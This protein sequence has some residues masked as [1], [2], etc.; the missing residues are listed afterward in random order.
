VTNAVYYYWY[1]YVKL[2]LEGPTLPK[3]V[4]SVGENMLTG[5]AAGA[6][7]SLI[8]N[9]IWVINTRL[10]V[11]KDSLDDKKAAKTPVV[12]KKATFL[13][14]AKVIKKFKAQENIQRRRN[15]WI[16]QGNNSCPCS[17]Y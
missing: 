14:V 9:P 8:T 2:V 11:K 3:R 10:V 4:L 7:T 6:M 15:G 5:A 13:S 1:E 17:C 16:F 12:D